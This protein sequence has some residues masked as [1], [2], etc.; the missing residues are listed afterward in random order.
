MIAK[1]ESSFAWL[2][3]F[4]DIASIESQMACGFLYFCHAVYSFTPIFLVCYNDSSKNFIFL[5]GQQFV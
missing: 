2:R 4:E 3:N 1:Q 5:A